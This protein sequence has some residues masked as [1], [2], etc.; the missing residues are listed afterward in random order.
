[1]TAQ[2]VARLYRTVLGHLEAGL[3]RRTELVPAAHRE[4][5]RLLLAAAVPL[6]AADAL[7]LALA[8]RGEA[9]TVLTYDR[10]LS[11]AVRAVGLHAFP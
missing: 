7:H 6:R 2:V 8:I 5:E 1:M 11:D 10:G 4:A 9:S 3:Y